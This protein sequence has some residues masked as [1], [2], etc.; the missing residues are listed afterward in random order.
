MAGRLTGG[1][2]PR[3]PVK[4]GKRR[5]HFAVV[6]DAGYTGKAQETVIE[7]MLARHKVAAF[8]AVIHLGDVYFKLSEPGLAKT[9]WLWTLP[10]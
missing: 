10:K 6:G 2:W 8:D 9:S 5:S 4:I 1:P 7:M 3:G